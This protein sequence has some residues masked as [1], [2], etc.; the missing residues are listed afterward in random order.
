MWLV[1]IVPLTFLL[2]HCMQAMMVSNR[3]MIM[4]SK[5]IPSPT[6]SQIASVGRP[7][8]VPSVPPAESVTEPSVLLVAKTSVV[9]AVVVMLVVSTTPLPSLPA[10]KNSTLQRVSQL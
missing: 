2:E 4:R 10:G 5:A 9:D 6:I 3:H 1:L 7:P 8:N